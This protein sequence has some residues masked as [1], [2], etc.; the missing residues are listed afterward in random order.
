MTFNHAV[1]M[2]FSALLALFCYFAFMV[3]ASV[4]VN[5]DDGASVLFALLAAI[6]SV[7][8]TAWAIMEFAS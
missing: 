5:E 4:A 7:A 1:A 2:A 8:S 3:F 6:G